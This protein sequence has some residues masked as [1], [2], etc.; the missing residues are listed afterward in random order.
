MLSIVTPAFNEASNLE[1]LYARLVRF[2]DRIGADW[3]WIVVDD[4]SPDDTFG[5]IERLA[6]GDSR[7]RGL[8]L[9]RHA[10]SHVAI[11]CGLHHARGDAAVMMAADLQDPPEIIEAMMVEWRQGA[12]IVWASRRTA[13]SLFSALYYRLMRNVV[14]MT[15]MPAN[16]A[17]FFL[18]DRAVLDAFRQFPERNVSVLALITWIGFRQVSVEYDKQPRL[19]G[20]SGWTLAARVRLVMDSVT[21]FSDFPIRLCAYLGAALMLLATVTGVV[22]IVMLPSIKAAMLGVVAMMLGLTGIQLLALGIVGEYVCRALD[23]ARRRPQYLIERI[24]PQ[25]PAAPISAR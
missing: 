24:V 17:D 18:V 2:F 1:A 16:G 20:T 14:G 22:A 25:R 10:G 8:R 7:V 23:E 4:H 15:D 19:A 12:Q 11:T 21:A 3:E 6:L 5:V 13:P 9:A